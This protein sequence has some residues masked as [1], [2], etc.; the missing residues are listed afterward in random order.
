[1]PISQSYLREIEEKALKAVDKKALYG[2][3]H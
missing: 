1:M 2:P 3:G